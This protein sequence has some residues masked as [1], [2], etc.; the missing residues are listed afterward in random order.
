MQ[1]SLN[2]ENLT[3]TWQLAGASSIGKSH[4]DS[5][6]PNQD[7][8]FYQQTPD[9]N[10]AVVCDGAGSAKLSEQ[11]SRYFAQAVGDFLL[12]NASNFVT[13]FTQTHEVFEL[14]KNNLA[15]IRQNLANQIP[16][17]FSPKDYHSTVTAILILPT[18]NQAL[19]VQIGDSPLLS[20][21]FIQKHQQ[22]DYFD[23]L[24]VFGDD[25]KAE[26]INETH[27]ITQD[28][29]Q[30]FLR[31][32]WLDTQNVD[33]IALMTDG[34]ADLVLAG[35]TLPR[36]VYRPFFA[37]VVFNLLQTPS[38]EVGNSLLQ[39]ALGNP[40]TYRLTG[41]DK[42]LV[43]LLKNPQS[44][45]SLEPLVEMPTQT[46]TNLNNN[47]LSENSPSVWTNNT[48][49]PIENRLS[50]STA[51]P[52]V[53]NTTPAENANSAPISQTQ[54]VQN[55]PSQKIST[56]PEKLPEPIAPANSPQTK[57]LL[58]A[59]GGM[60]LG[61]LALAGLNRDWLSEKFSAKTTVAPPTTATSTPSATA[62][63]VTADS[64]PTTTELPTPDS[65]DINTPLTLHSLN[66][67][68]NMVIGFPDGKIISPITTPVKVWENADRAVFAK[69]A[70]VP[71][72]ANDQ[73]VFTSFNITVNPAWH[74]AKCQVTLEPM[75]L[76]AEEA[77][78]LK[79]AK[80]QWQKS[81]LPPEIKE[82]VLPHGLS[83]VFPI[84]KPVE[85][86]SATGSVVNS[87]QAYFLP[88]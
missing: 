60:L 47:S 69:A 88:K 1:N 35:G 25:D 65:H 49:N 71:V 77:K 39:T 50:I 22:L 37:N 80:K 74:Y 19:L 9:F 81:A 8:F 31:I 12:Q 28:N 45:Q 23:N 68:L 27:F 34:C 18:L 21:Q 14:I 43:V 52:L 33:C 32:E 24:Q 30:D 20:S 5:E 72:L 15:T 78:D 61:V 53:E 48:E 36:Q 79:V 11:G 76:N 63:T 3:P 56:T 57:K 70:C 51:Q 46:I 83:P 40:A 26:Y 10:V 2:N 54:I 42:T 67:P 87:L 75:S 16:A 44:W 6:L 13:N 82:V 64:E 38:Q 59:G 58:L 29:W 55:S 62:I 73:N 66:E 7:S 4:L 85:T 17:E 84:Q 86:A 41:D